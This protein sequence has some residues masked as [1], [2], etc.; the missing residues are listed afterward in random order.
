VRTSIQVP[1][2]MRRLSDAEPL[3]E[4]GLEC[5]VELCEDG[6]VARLA[7]FPGGASVLTGP[8]QTHLHAQF[9][10]VNNDYRKQ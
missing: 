3:D 10:F 8:V 5:H 2:I 9:E 6:W 4:L 7:L 1:E